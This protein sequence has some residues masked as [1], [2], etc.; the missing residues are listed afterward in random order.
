MSCDLATARLCC[1]PA[2]KAQCVAGQHI[3]EAVRGWC[4]SDGTISLDGGLSQLASFLSLK[5]QGDD[6]WAKLDAY[7][8]ASGDGAELGKE[9]GLAVPPATL[10]LVPGQVA[11]PKV[12]GHII[13]EPPALPQTLAD[14][15]KEENAFAIREPPDKLA[16]SF[17]SVSSWC[18]LAVEF[19]ERGLCCLLPESHGVMHKG[20][21]V[22]AGLFGVPKKLSTSA[23]L[24]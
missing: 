13:L 1:R 5:M 14:I 23:R 7:G 16:P 4:R 22:S 15:L 20:H 21:R 24:I 10:E 12:A 6:I 11:L 17:T 2:S 9:S 3:F 19:L 8:M 18:D